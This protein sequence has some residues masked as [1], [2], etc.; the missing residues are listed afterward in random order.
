MPREIV[1]TSEITLIG[2]GAAWLPHAATLVVADVHLGYA[3]AAR[4]RGG[5]LPAAESAEAAADRVLAAA[6]RVGATRLVI[7]GDLRHSTHDV[8]DGERADVRAF[9]ARLASLDRVELVAGNHDRGD[10]EM[11]P[12]ARIGSVSVVHAPPTS[13][14]DHWVICGHLHPTVTLRDETGAGA[15]YPCALVGASIIV[16]PAFSAWAGGVA[17]R[18]LL[19]SLPPGDWTTYPIA[20]GEIYSF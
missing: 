19:P 3:R 14:P 17:V 2:E 18:R 5:Y 10:D 7:A 20:G 16:L 1:I 4:R 6:R 12:S 13:A 8:D 9:R 11:T 15:R